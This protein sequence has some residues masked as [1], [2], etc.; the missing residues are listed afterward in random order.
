MA[1]YL[2]CAESAKLLRQALKE[3]FPGVKFSVR[4]SVYSMGASISVQWND[5]PSPKLVEAVADRFEGSYFDGMI[6]YKGSK[7]AK[8]DGEEV[9]FGSDSVRCSR[10]ESDA[11]VARAIRVVG[12]RYNGVPESVSVAAFRNGE[13]LRVNLFDNG[14]EWEPRWNWQSALNI[15]L[16]KLSD[17]AVIAESATLKR[18]Q[19][20]GDD[21][22]GAGTVGRD[23]EGGSQA[24]VAMEA[25]REREAQRQREAQQGD[26]L[27]K[28]IIRSV[29]LL[30]MPAVGGVQ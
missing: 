20:A 2:S 14:K 25:A 29:A 28:D 7:Y 26:E 10:Q 23:G 19:P 4:S 8:L 21:G 18:L 27:I 13:L 12:A 11:L 6:D 15:E 3:S 22:Y 17:R 9:R 16:G 1:K 30:K 24:Y 5:G